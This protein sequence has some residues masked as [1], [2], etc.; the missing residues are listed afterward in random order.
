M[1]AHVKPAVSLAE[2]SRAPYAEMSPSLLSQQPVSAPD[3]A[4]ARDL[5]WWNI[6][7]T[8]LEARL[9]PALGVLPAAPPALADRRQPHESRL[10][11]Q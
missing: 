4:K 9:A 10:A 7:Y 1:N 6:A 8:H 3:V 5:S 11:R 2:A